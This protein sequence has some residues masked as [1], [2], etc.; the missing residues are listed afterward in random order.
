[1]D[2]DFENIDYTSGALLE[3]E[4]APE[5]DE[6]MP[7][8]EEVLAREKGPVF[9]PEKGK[10]KVKGAGPSVAFD[11]KTVPSQV[12]KA[13]YMLAMVIKNRTKLAEFLNELSPSERK[14]LRDFFTSSL[15]K[16]YTDVD[17]AFFLTDKAQIKTCSKAIPGKTDAQP[18]MTV[19]QKTMLKTFTT[20]TMVESSVGTAPEIQGATHDRVVHIDALNGS[21]ACYQYHQEEVRAK[22][23]NDNITPENSFAMFERKGLVKAADYVQ[24]DLGKYVSEAI[25]KVKVAANKEVPANVATYLMESGLAGKIAPVSHNIKPVLDRMCS[26]VQL[27]NVNAFS[28]LGLVFMLDR[29]GKKPVNDIEFVKNFPSVDLDRYREHE[30]LLKEFFPPVPV[31]VAQTTQLALQ[32]SVSRTEYVHK[33]QRAAMEAAEVSHNNRI[34][35]LKYPVRNHSTKKL[36]NALNSLT[37]TQLFDLER[38]LSA[39]ALNGKAPKKRPMRVAIEIDAHSAPVAIDLVRHYFP[40]TTHISVYTG[41]KYN[42]SVLDPKIMPSYENIMGL[43]GV[44]VLFG[45][46][47]NLKGGSVANLAGGADS[48]GLIIFAKPF[49]HKELKSNETWADW[50]A[51]SEA[52]KRLITALQNR[53]FGR[54]DVIMP[55]FYGTGKP[56]DGANLLEL[57]GGWIKNHK[58]GVPQVVLSGKLHH[59]YF[60]TVYSAHATSHIGTAF[61]SVKKALKMCSRMEPIRQVYFAHCFQFGAELVDLR[62]RLEKEFVTGYQFYK[63]LFD[64]VVR[65][66]PKQRDIERPEI[67]ALPSGPIGGEEDIE[68]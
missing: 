44:K 62:N 61:A 35:R 33:L 46:M 43:E 45:S 34:I 51:N 6:L 39:L 38:C 68:F 54:K 40:D 59:P 1:M 23:E 55:F 22:Q 50:R 7:S 8:T 19:H 31:E 18:I 64:F 36:S 57:L 32:K 52:Q 11:V 37:T 10:E 14:V 66:V 28:A 47:F 63:F 49:V 30:V 24:I 16:E 25:V 17:T 9:E 48:D 60:W 5:E 42:T 53:E 2:A 12:W 29:W 65:N 21:V 58:D 20:Q 27:T 13:T 56:G 3:D 4:F 26:S 15:G 67:E 41:G